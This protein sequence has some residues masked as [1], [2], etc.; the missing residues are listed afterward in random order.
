MR[1]IYKNDLCVYTL[2]DI[3]DSGDCFLKYLASGAPVD[4]ASKHKVPIQNMVGAGTKCGIEDVL[5]FI[6]TKNL[7]YVDLPAIFNLHRNIFLN[8]SSEKNPTAINF[9]MISYVPKPNSLLETEIKK[10]LEFNPSHYIVGNI[11]TT[12]FTCFTVSK[13]ENNK[14]YVN[15]IA[16]ELPGNQNENFEISKNL[17]A[18][19][20]SITGMFKYIDNLDKTG[21]LKYLN[22][23][24][25]KSIN[26][27]IVV[28]NG[29][30][31]H[32]NCG[33]IKPVK[34]GF[35]SKMIEKDFV[36]KFKVG[37]IV[38]NDCS[39]YEI[40]KISDNT[41]LG[42][43][44]LANIGGD[45][46]VKDEE[47]TLYF[48]DNALQ[49]KSE[50][51][52]FDILTSTDS[53][54]PQF[55]DVDLLLKHYKNL[56]IVSNLWGEKFFKLNK[57]LYQL[58]SKLDKY[59]NE[60]KYFGKIVKN[61]YGTYF[62]TKVIGNDIYG[63]CLYSDMFHQLNLEYELSQ[64][65][66]SVE[67]SSNK[68]LDGMNKTKGIKSIDINLLLSTVKD[69][70]ILKTK[71][72]N[73]K[74]CNKEKS[75]EIKDGEF[76]EPIKQYIEKFP[77]KLQL[78][79]PEIVETIPLNV[80]PKI[81]L[82]LKNEDFCV[83]DIDKEKYLL[84]VLDA[85][86]YDC[87]I[88]AT[89]TDHLSQHTKN[90][91]SFYLYKDKNL[92]PMSDI[93]I[94]DFIDENKEKLK[95]IDFDSFNESKKLEFVSF[96]S[97]ITLHPKNKA[98]KTIEISK[99]L[100]VYRTHN[101][102]SVDNIKKILE[103]TEKS[104][105]E[106]PP[107]KY[108]LF[109]DP[110]KYNYLIYSKQDNTYKFY[111]EMFQTKNSKEPG[112]KEHIDSI[113]QLDRIYEFGSFLEMNTFIYECDVL[114]CVWENYD[115]NLIAYIASKNTSNIKPRDFVLCKNGDIFRF[116]P[117]ESEINLLTIYDPIARVSNE[118]SDLKIDKVISEDE[119]KHLLRTQKYAYIN[120]QYTYDFKI[121]ENITEE[122]INLWNLGLA[123]L[124]SWLVIKSNKYLKSNPVKEI[125][126]EI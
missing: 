46:S 126:G 53:R 12:E 27:K 84:E 112:L 69:L 23:D 108:Y 11:Y 9:D 29:T 47:Y 66:I 49:I 51:D 26:S 106:N 123:G 14:I 17:K 100:D 56:E 32:E 125:K 96:N 4:D 21:Q 111:A 5:E 119:V 120:F 6:V 48:K 50:S 2:E 71:E 8:L 34:K 45:I 20:V 110:R 60:H 88:I 114:N 73:F 75:Y 22:L 121:A 107:I 103:Q 122:P 33:Y 98:A 90:L 59:I 77:E 92:S 16:S 65:C 124:A 91:K 61:S 36:S 10:Y 37:D 76:V 104:T 68:I 93:E 81:E 83:L 97:N 15:V 118:T 28:E 79:I 78:E 94:F 39:I 85:D 43:C 35:L 109:R 70:S 30:I 40:T 52:I 105:A 13:I 116:L 38:G 1:K 57:K 95:F 101:K 54:K 115:K 44:V 31:F 80:L 67:D 87:K 7:K 113:S 99:D 74:I 25:M 86:N 62:I 18:E 63:K 24:V 19:L 41:I 89:T 72:G 117:I 82:K 55:I 58:N 64:L 3:E 42:K 102:F